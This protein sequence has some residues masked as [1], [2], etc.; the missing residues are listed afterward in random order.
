MQT[1]T[2]PQASNTMEEGT[3]V[4]WLKQ[5]GDVVQEGEILL[6]IETDKATVEVPSPAGGT[7]RA[8]LVPAGEYAPIHAPIA[9]I[10]APDEP[11]EGVPA[12]ADA[13]AAPTPAPQP[14]SAS[15]PAAPAPPAGVTPLVM[16]QA[17][18]TM[19]EGTIVRWLVA[20]GDRIEVG[21]VV[22]EIETDKATVELE[23]AHAGRLA[24]ILAGAGEV[25]PV[26]APIALLAESDADAEAW[27]A[28]QT[29]A[30]AAAAP[31]PP[32]QAAPAASPAPVQPAPAPTAGGRP[33]ASPAARRIA[34][35]RGIDLAQ[36]PAGSGPGGRILSTD[37]PA[38][39]GASVVQPP[40]AQSVGAQPA[41]G[42]GPGRPLAGMRRAIAR[43]LT[44]SK[45]TIPH[46]YMRLTV[47]AGL[48][49]R[50][51]RSGP[52]RAPFTLNDIVVAAAARCMAEFPQFRTR[53]E[54]DRLVD[55][56][57]ANIGIAVGTEDA[58]V[59]PVL[60]A[61]DQLGLRQ[62]G[63]STRRL[64]QAA[65]EGKIL[66]AGQG[67]LTISNLGMFGVEE[68]TAIINPPEAAILAVS[69][70]REEV[71][72]R[73]G[74]MRPGRVMTITMSADHRVIDG[75]I[76]ARFMARLKAL[77]EAPDVLLNT[78]E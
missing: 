75:M 59:V 56:P 37:L 65:R 54:N 61:A 47:D 31:A 62:I 29:G 40:F 77:L 19:E 41:A 76:A 32:S 9:L 78:P 35:E 13:V 74:A 55:Y 15:A 46:F 30:L 63:A 38:A 23:A 49:V 57:H 42:V 8:I 60:P 58:L 71:I 18:N 24:R 33:K 53:L 45:Q 20:P 26:K 11:L 39:A 52:G 72:V 28:S 34:A 51:H 64:V 43:N 69:A 17:G 27:L 6:E 22:C 67:Q 12:P 1:V 48:M 50:L 14:V 44:L 5:V 73:D 7:L 16:P 3:V 68:F 70:I 21:Q 36:L 10:G 2:M 4:R 25:V 66:N